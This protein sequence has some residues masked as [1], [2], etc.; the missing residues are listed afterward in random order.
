MC[1]FQNPETGGHALAIP[2]GS[3]WSA[4]LVP[5]ETGAESVV[6]RGFFDTGLGGQECK[7]M[8]SEGTLKSVS[9]DFSAC[10]AIE[11]WDDDVELTGMPILVFT[12]AQIAAQTVCSVPAMPECVIRLIGQVPVDQVVPLVASGRMVYELDG[13]YWAADGDQTVPA[14]TTVVDSLG[15]SYTVTRLD[16][17]R[18]FVDA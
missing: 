4:E 5:G 17:E 16:S 13:A 6:T 2:A 15:V 7:R 9:V 1:Q 12:K 18:V 8:L 11:I 10:E 14:E 3:V